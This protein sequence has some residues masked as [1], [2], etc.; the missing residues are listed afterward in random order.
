LIYFSTFSDFFISFLIHD[1]VEM[2]SKYSKVS[3]I[4]APS[5]TIG[6]HGTSEVSFDA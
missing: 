1:F 5:V 4:A 6:Q 3:F 2:A